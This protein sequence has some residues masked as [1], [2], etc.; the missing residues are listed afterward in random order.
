MIWNQFRLWL[1][2]AKDLV[3]FT[4]DHVYGTYVLSRRVCSALWADQ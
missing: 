1:P 4:C 3:D 2:Q